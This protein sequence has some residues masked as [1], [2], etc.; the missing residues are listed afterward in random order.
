LVSLASLTNHLRVRS[1]KEKKPNQANK[2]NKETQM[3][4]SQVL[5]R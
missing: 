2:S 1:E 5:M 3:I 4:L